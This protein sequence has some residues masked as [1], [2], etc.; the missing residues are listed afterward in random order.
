M[1]PIAPAVP[2]TLD[3]YVDLFGRRVEFMSAIWTTGGVVG[4]PAL[5]VTPL[6]NPG[7][8]AKF[9]LQLTVSPPV[10]GSAMPALFTYATDLFDAAT[11]GGA[12][13]LGRDDIGR[14]AVGAKADLFMADLDHPAMRPVREPLRSLIP[15]IRA[16]HDNRA[17]RP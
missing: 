2:P 1:P 5:R 4:H 13:I 6:D 11:V 9:D 14:L 12:T 7:A 16:A 3:N 8:I 10:S 15:H 17:Q